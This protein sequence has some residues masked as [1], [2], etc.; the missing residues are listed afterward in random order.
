MTA[1]LCSFLERNLPKVEAGKK[2]EFSLGVGEPNLCSNIFR[3][4][5]FPCL[6]DHFVLELL[7]GVELHINDLL[8]FPK[9]GNLKLDEA[10]T[11]SVV[12]ERKRSKGKSEGALSLLYHKLVDECI[13]EDLKIGKQNEKAATLMGMVSIHYTVKRRKDDKMLLDTTNGDPFKFRLGTCQVIEALDM[14][15]CGMYVGGERRLTVPPT[16]GYETKSGRGTKGVSGPKGARGHWIV[17]DVRLVD[18]DF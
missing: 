11:E 10:P 2:P 14:G 8:E 4:T 9:P 5:N 18:A 7:R 12:E 3:A 15:I 13:V 1:E 6:R 16:L 17:V